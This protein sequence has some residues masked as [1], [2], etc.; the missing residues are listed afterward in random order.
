MRRLVLASSARQYA[1]P[2]SLRAFSAEA[3]DAAGGDAGSLGRGRGRGAPVDDAA[4]DA[5]GAPGRGRGRGLAGGS[6]LARVFS[7][8]PTPAQEAQSKL[9]ASVGPPPPPAPRPQRDGPPR[10]ITVRGRGRDAP[11]PQPA[12]GVSGRPDPAAAAQPRS[13]SVTR[14]G[15]GAGREYTRRRGPGGADG[16]ARAGGTG[17]LQQQQQRSGGEPPMRARSPQG[18]RRGG[19]S[20]DAA[21]GAPPIAPATLRHA[22]LFALKPCPNPRALRFAVLPSAQQQR[23]ERRSSRWSDALP[24]ALSS[25][26]QPRSPLPQLPNLQ[27]GAVKR[28]A[29]APRGALSSREEDEEALDEDDEAQFARI[30]RKQTVSEYLDI[31]IDP[32][33][34]T[35]EV[36]HAPVLWGTR[37]E[38]RAA[39]V[40]A[41][42]AKAAE[43]QYKTLGRE[44]AGELLEMRQQHYEEALRAA[45]DEAAAK[46][47]KA[48]AS[49]LGAWH[50]ALV[51]EQ[52]KVAEK[53][54]SARFGKIAAEA[55]L[56]REQ[57]EAVAIR[58]GG[59][60]LPHVAAEDAA[61]AQ[62]GT[63]AEGT[64]GE[65]YMRRLMPLLLRNSSMTYADKQ[66]ALGI[67]LHQVAR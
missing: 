13:P 8:A 53:E 36:G 52:D 35:A 25:R 27:R 31:A 17:R 20:Q 61:L 12:A 26:Q 4:P 51:A 2:G 22:S 66:R 18:H 34:S 60:G 23:G 42:F 3:G 6:L 57:E 67:V 30:R 1:A 64:A 14:S 37:P 47:I 54:V 62:V 56:L 45:P 44:F 15:D 41:H 9:A 29:S 28:S 46:A 40:V 10:E 7:A 19:P 38:R 16:E 11:Q 59:S 5:P 55:E 65:A 58:K 33:L 48:E 43:A 50:A 49:A 39:E 63:F 32:V 21:G 24:S